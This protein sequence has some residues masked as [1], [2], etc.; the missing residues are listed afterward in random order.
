MAKLL[1]RKNE[2][3]SVNESKNLQEQISKMKNSITDLNVTV[4]QLNKTVSVLLLK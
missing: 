2:K 4:E 3:K 1:K